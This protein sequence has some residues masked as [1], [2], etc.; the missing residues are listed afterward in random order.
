MKTKII[1]SLI[2]LMG[3]PILSKAQKDTTYFVFNGRL[4]VSNEIHSDTLSY[5]LIVYNDWHHMEVSSN[6]GVTHILFHWRKPETVRILQLSEISNQKRK[7]NLSFLTG[8]SAKMFINT[9]DYFQYKHV[10]Y[11]IPLQEKDENGYKVYQFMFDS[12]F[13][14]VE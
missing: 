7:Y 11:I 10:Y 13:L 2:I 14:N 9:F 4:N 3:I 1:V 12:D 5:K 6:Y 8:L